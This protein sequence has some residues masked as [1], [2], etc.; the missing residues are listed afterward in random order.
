MICFQE[1]YSNC[2]FCINKFSIKNVYIFTVGEN[3]QKIMG[4]CDKVEPLQPEVICGLIFFFVSWNYYD[5]VIY[6]N[7][8]SHKQ[9]WTFMYSFNR[10]GWIQQAKYHQ[11]V[12]LS[13]SPRR[14]KVVEIES[15]H[16]LPRHIIVNKHNVLR[17][18]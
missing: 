1:Q 12:S 6:S 9:N 4:K 10:M 2:P 3:K 7:M 5:F 15:D 14:V 8:R 13:V 11:F 17:P 16:S 18:K